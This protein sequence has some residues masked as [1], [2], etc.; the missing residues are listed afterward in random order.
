[1]LYIFAVQL[2]LSPLEMLKIT[3]RSW[4]AFNVPCQLP[5]RSCAS[6]PVPN[7]ATSTT[8]HSSGLFMECPPINAVLGDGGKAYLL[9]K[10]WVICIV[11]LYLPK[12]QVLPLAK[13]QRR[14]LGDPRQT[15]IRDS[16]NSHQ[17]L[18]SSTWELF[19]PSRIPRPASG[20]E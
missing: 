1:M 2:S 18:G 13:Q 4:P 10:F 5:E 8:T 17:T 3:R 12:F 15:G 20:R 7:I 6:A 14:E 19:Y 11:F 9:Q 16:R